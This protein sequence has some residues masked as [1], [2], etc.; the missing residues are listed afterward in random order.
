MTNDGGVCLPYSQELCVMGLLFDLAS[1]SRSLSMTTA[2][3]Y[4]EIETT[5]PCRYV[6][7]MLLCGMEVGHQGENE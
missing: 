3:V 4:D 7:G 6:C 1:R 5:S 2:D